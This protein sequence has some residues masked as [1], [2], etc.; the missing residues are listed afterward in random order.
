MLQIKVT[1]VSDNNSF[2]TLFKVPSL[3]FA[4]SSYTCI[5]GSSNFSKGGG[6]KILK[7]GDVLY[8]LFDFFFKFYL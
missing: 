5:R 4:K 8:F 3:I 7:L 2:G 1:R 6:F